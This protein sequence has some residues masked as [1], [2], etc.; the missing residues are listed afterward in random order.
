M[1]TIAC[2]R[3]GTKFHKDYVNILYERIKA[4]LSVPFKFICASDDTGYDEG[5]EVVKLPEGLEG[6]WGKLWLF[7]KE[8]QAHC[9]DRIL[10]IDLDTII[11]NHFDELAEYKGDF[12]ILR[13]FYRPDGY[14]SGLMA[15]KNGFNYIWETW[16]KAGRP[17]LEGGDQSWIEQSVFGADRWQDKYPGKVVSY[18]VHA[19]TLPP[20]AQIV[21]FH[22]KPMP[23][24]IIGGW[25]PQMF[26][27]GGIKRV[28]IKEGTNVPSDQMLKNVEINCQRKLPQFGALSQP[29]GGTA[30][31]I[32]G[33]PSLNENIKHIRERA[34]KGQTIWAVNGSLK[35]LLLNGITPDVF[36]MMD[37]RSENVK[38]LSDT[39]DIE[40]LINAMCDPEA[41]EMLKGRNVTMWHSYNDQEEKHQKILKEK[42]HGNPGVIDGGS[43]VVLNSMFLA[44][45]MGYRRIHLYGVDSS[46]S[47]GKHHAYDQKWNDDAGVFFA[48][49]KEKEYAC[50]AW[51]V[52]QVECFR[53]MWAELVDRGCTV[54]AHGNG[55]L[56]D[57]CRNLNDE[58]R[59]KIMESKNGKSVSNG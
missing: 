16:D 35:H 4:Q 12:I 44:F 10:F 7:S 39:P 8:F 47:D 42:G 27:R 3:W 36:C 52:K 17:K 29:H 59:R 38:F 15:W 24:D 41:F 54:N 43:T 56:P 33:A 30:V 2:V 9:T 58:L 45:Y 5:I 46:Y 25:V 32:G 23:H 34:R 22:G 57:V 49:Y 37:A 20:D 21:C 50:T 18:K 1:L 55:L 13:D 19:E 14:G 11:V 6:W 28:K 31:I 26:R 48:T 51:M 40:Y 53:K